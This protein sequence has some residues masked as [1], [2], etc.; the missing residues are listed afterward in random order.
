VSRPLEGRV[1]LVTGGGR[2]IGKGIA[3]RLARDGGRVV[4]A[5]RDE[6]SA[7]EAVEQIT[8]DG[9]IA[10]F[11]RTDIGSPADVQAAVDFVVARHE[12]LDILVNNAGA[13]GADGSILDMPLEKWQ[14]MVDVNLTS[15]FVASQAAARVMVEKGDGGRIINIGSINSFRAQP[16]ACNYVAT[17]G[18]IPLLTMA[19]A[20]DLS[21]HNI[22][23]NAIA[24]GAI[25]TER[26]GPRLLNPEYRGMIERSIPLRRTGLVEEIAA[27]AAFLAS[28]EATYIQGETIA[29]DGGILAYLRLD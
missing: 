6:A 20:M 8:T 23:V 15:V 24:P 11:V 25:S 21:P 13:T 1:A 4:I 9:G 28:G 14:R 18:A 12:R 17:K 3:R 19:L 26:T 7:Q 29:V 16:M 2:G 27:V 10:D 5:Q 22:L